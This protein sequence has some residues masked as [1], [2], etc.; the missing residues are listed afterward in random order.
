MAF[1]GFESTFCVL[2]SSPGKLICPCIILFLHRRDGFFTHL[3]IP[4]LGASEGALTSDRAP[5][6]LA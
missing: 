2:Q 6:M 3:T 4:S 1:R 5:S